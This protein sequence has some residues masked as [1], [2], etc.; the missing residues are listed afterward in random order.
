M[1]QKNITTQPW[2]VVLNSNIHSICVVTKNALQKLSANLC[3]GPP[4]TSPGPLRHCSSPQEVRPEPNLHEE[5]GWWG[6][7]G[8]GWG[9]DTVLDGVDDEHQ[10]GRRRPSTREEVQ[11]RERSTPDHMLDKTGVGKS[12]PEKLNC[13]WLFFFCKS[14][15]Q[16]APASLWTVP[17][18]SEEGKKYSWTSIL[19][20]TTDPVDY[21]DP[22]VFTQ[23]ATI[24]RYLMLSILSLG[25]TEEWRRLPPG[26]HNLF[27]PT[28]RDGSTWSKFGARGEH[29]DVFLFSNLGGLWFWENR[30]PVLG[31]FDV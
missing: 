30:A 8:P 21:V 3:H 16:E 20:N 26:L 25:W 28:I 23:Y 10:G 13:V 31:E 27:H 12:I 11:R 1:V 22:A 15:F 5:R 14:T 4:Q 17:V 6:P 18:V 24:I 9:P 19:R 7:R 2:Q 29:G